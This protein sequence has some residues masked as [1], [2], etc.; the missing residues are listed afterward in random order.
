MQIVIP[1][2]IVKRGKY[3]YLV[4]NIR[5][6]KKFSIYIGKDVDEHI[7]K[8]KEK[9]LEKKV[10]EYLRNIDPLFSLLSDE[11][12]EELET[13]KNK[14]LEILNK[15]PLE[16]KKKYYEWRLAALTYN[17]N[18]IEGSTLSLEETA[19]ILFE[20]I[21]PKGKTIREIKEAENHK[22]ALEYMLSYDRDLSLNFI[23]K[24]HKII[25]TGILENKYAGKLRDVQVFVRGSEINPP[26]PEVVEMELKELLRWYHRN[27]QRY[28]PIVVASY[29]HIAFEGIHPFIDFNG[30]VGRLILN[31]ILKKNFY[32]FA[33]IKVEDRIEYLKAIND[34]L[35]GDLRPFIKLLIKCLRTSPQPQD[36]LWGNFCRKYLIKEEES[37]HHKA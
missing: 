19:A 27:K 30:R 32:P 22:K 26:P 15:L 7:L 3:H 37:E 21:A 28:H 11:E 6:N 35:K 4:K 31:F 34:G 2:N 10:R 36:G 23:L 17:S 25:S 12:L 5:I 18:A 1:E 29:F 20:G 33:D 14:N 13:I 24:L 9:N 8:K 16:A